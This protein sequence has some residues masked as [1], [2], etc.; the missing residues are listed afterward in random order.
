MEVDVTR[1]TLLVLKR[2]PYCKRQNNKHKPTNELV[3]RV[4]RL[5]PFSMNF[6]LGFFFIL[7]FTKGN[8]NK[9]LFNPTQNQVAN[10]DDSHQLVMWY[11]YPLFSMLSTIRFACSYIDFFFVVIVVIAMDE[12]ICRDDD[13]IKI[14]FFFCFLQQSWLIPE[15]GIQR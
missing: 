9:F 13:Q 10:Q 4:F 1:S 11:L 14:L 8:L 7:L 2:C 5:W 6:S 3:K 12:E 15:A